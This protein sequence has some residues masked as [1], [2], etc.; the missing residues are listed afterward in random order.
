MGQARNDRKMEAG[1]EKF[2]GMDDIEA[3][4]LDFLAYRRERRMKMTQP[5]P[6]LIECRPESIE[7]IAP[8]CKPEA[9]ASHSP[10]YMPEPNISPSLHYMPETVVSHDPHYMP[11]P[12]E[13]HTPP[14]ANQVP[15]SIDN[16]HHS[17]SDAHHPISD[18]HYSTN[19]TLHSIGKG[20]PHYK[21]M[22]QGYQPARS[23]PVPS[24]TEPSAHVPP[25][26]EPSS[27]V[28]PAPK[29]SPTMPPPPEP[30]AS[31]N[32]SD[33]IPTLAPIV[34]KTLNHF[35]SP[36]NP[37]ALEHLIYQ[38]IASAMTIPLI[39]ESMSTAEITPWGRIPLL[40]AVIELLILLQIQQMQ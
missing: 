17:I 2:T 30:T 10:H 31:S 15:Y 38:V 23:V 27:S 18:A 40:Q 16:V 7:P 9:I 14:K 26:F 12:I 25:T 32:Q 24:A 29:S 39:S 1:M 36:A 20:W 28:P 37:K 21:K 13:H 34:T 6:K 4:V 33:L 8:Q 11:E 5:P 19:N 3:L 22:A 35:G